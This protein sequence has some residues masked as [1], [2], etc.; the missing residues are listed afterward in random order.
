MNNYPVPGTSA[1][2]ECS[3]TLYGLTVL[4]ALT[5]AGADVVIV[6]PHLV[7]FRTGGFAAL[8]SD[9]MMAIMMIMECGASSCSASFLLV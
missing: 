2:P 4:L 8:P 7:C 3:V 6:M 1:G 5:L 9:A